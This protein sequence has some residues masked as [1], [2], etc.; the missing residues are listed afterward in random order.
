MKSIIKYL[1]LTTS[2]F[3]FIIGLVFAFNPV[4]SNIV[5]NYFLVIALGIIGI[6][7]ICQYLS[8]PKTSGW[9]LVLGILSII[10][11]FLLLDNGVVAIQ[12]SVG[13]ILAFLAIIGGIRQ[14]FIAPEASKFFGDSIAW[15]ITTGIIEILLGIM[16]F[17]APIAFQS[18]IYFFIGIF[19]IVYSVIAF[20]RGITIKTK[21]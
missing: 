3:A 17:C 1:I 11:C 9:E 5:M 4:G 18:L 2:I 21:K 8:V 7:K 16:L 12:L 15:Y 6:T 10:A 14:F 13:Y 20:A 19:L